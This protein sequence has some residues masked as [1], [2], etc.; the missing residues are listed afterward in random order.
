[1]VGNHE[2]GQDG[3][4]WE[5]VDSVIRTQGRLARQNVIYEIAG[6]TSFAK[7]MINESFVSAWRLIMKEPMLKLIKKCSDAEANRQL[8][9][10]RWSV[11]LEELDGF[12][13]LLYARF[14]AKNLLIH[15]LCSNTW[16]VSFWRHYVMQ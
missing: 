12:I 11:S 7:C 16:G 10:N 13:A 4:K 8:Q 2:Y 1:M 9:H 6:P 15:S 5:T 3:T 14:G